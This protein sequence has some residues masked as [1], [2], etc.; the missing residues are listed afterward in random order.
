MTTT[1]PYLKELRILIVDDSAV[2]RSVLSKELLK[3]GVEV[4]QAENGQQAMDIAL[5]KEFDLIIT[6]VEMPVMDGIELCRKLK[7]NPRTQQIP[8]VILSSLDREEDVKRGYKAGATTYIS[9]AQAKDSLIETIETVLQKSTF[10]RGRLILVVDDSNTIR[11]LVE[12]G[13]KEVGFEVVKAENGQAGLDF[14][15]GGRRPDLILSDIDMPVMNGEEFCRTVHMDPVLA[16]IPFV[17]MS[18]NNDRP[19]MRRMLQL[20]ADSY[21]VKPFN[22]DQLVITVEKLLSDKLLLLHKEKER[23]EIEQRLILASITSLCN[24]L[25]ARDSYTRGHSEAVSDIATRIATEMG[26]SQEDIDHVKLGGKLH[27]LG[28]IGVVDNVL[29]KPGKL[30]DEEFAIIQK[31]PVI[32]ADILRPVPSLAKILPIVLYH[33]ERIDGKGYPEGLKGDS[34]P[35]WARITAVGDTYHALTSDR[36]YRKG[37]ERDKALQ[38]IEEVS[39]TQ[40]CPDCVDVFLRMQLW[41]GDPDTASG[42]SLPGDSPDKPLIEIPEPI[43]VPGGK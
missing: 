8:I 1:L 41:D 21:L 3:T 38:I 6:D 39:G 26:M 37:M 36:P 25:E 43:V 34:I 19:I 30:S 2:V 15:K 42:L 31:H 32:G 33:H 23:L 16:S 13:L 5:C 20:G 4:T 17:V 28:K 7:L 29:L 18:A 10:Q 22:I 35:L 27:D 11:T 24:A 14:L 12:K 9:K 40:L